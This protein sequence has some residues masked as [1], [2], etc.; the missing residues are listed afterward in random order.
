MEALYYSNNIKLLTNKPNKKYK[1][2]EQLLFYPTHIM[3]IPN[4][5]DTREDDI[6]S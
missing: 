3:K 2:Q 6:N 5:K 1:T 4:R